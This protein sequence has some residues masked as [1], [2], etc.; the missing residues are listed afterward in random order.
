MEIQCIRTKLEVLKGKMGMEGMFAVDC[1]GHSGG[2]VLFWKFTQG[3]SLLGYSS[4]FIDVEVHIL[5]WGHWR[6]SG[7]Y[8]CEASDRF[9]GSYSAH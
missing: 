7:F 2:L 8:Q 6:L 5:E 1:E 3:I 9:H 4:H